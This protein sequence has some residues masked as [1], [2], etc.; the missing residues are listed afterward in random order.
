MNSQYMISLSQCWQY[1]MIDRQHLPQKLLSFTKCPG[2]KSQKDVGI[3]N[4][5]VLFKL[6]FK[7]DTS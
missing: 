4:S 6:V 7:C 1:N 2:I 5:L 3:K